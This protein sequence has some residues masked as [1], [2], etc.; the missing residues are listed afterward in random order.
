MLRAR[1]RLRSSLACLFLPLALAGFAC[2]DAGG[3][4]G[5]TASSGATS[6]TTSTSGAST[7]SS[8]GGASSSSTGAGGASA[9]SSSSS[10]SSSGGG[11]PS[12][13][14]ILAAL[15]ADRDGELQKISASEGWPAL[16]DQGYLFV[17]AD[18]SLTELAGDHDMW[19]PEAM[20]V[21]Q[22]FSYLVEKTLPAMDHYK[23]TDGKTYASDPWSRAYDYDQYGE[24]SL[25]LPS[26]KR[27]ERFF[28]LASAKLGPRIVRVLVP[29]A[30][31]THVLYAHDG[32]NLFDPSA[33]YGGWQLEQSAPPAMLIV[34]IDNTP[35]RMDEY[36]HVPD[37]IQGMMVGGKGDDYADLVENVVRP[38]VKATY[39]EPKKVGVMGSSL[40]GL[41][42]FHIAD[43]LPGKY[44]FAASLSGTMGWGSIGQ[45]VHNQTM[46]ERYKAHGH[47]GTVLYLDS[48]GA[49]NCVDSDHDGI[50]DDDPNATDN[51]CENAQMKA[52]LESVGYQ[53]GKDL[54]Y[55]Y[56]PGQM[57]NEAAWAARVGNAMQIFAGL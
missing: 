32:E 14:D 9:S 51:Y 44:D 41:I 4:G 22:G 13:A 53:D 26:G 19:M 48:G 8:G 31:P 29:A 28:G 15:R 20:M 3:A 49:G 21:D 11:A 40:G 7:S 37:V 36:T 24:I 30:A 42:S 25:A 1:M 43:H 55:V 47:R 34:G 2:G 18:T 23:F 52:T 12:L 17:S 5:A 16:T 54:F 33:A 46:I 45:G 35:A 27:L 6:T 57:H 56:A 39:G 38:L 50:Q 10:S